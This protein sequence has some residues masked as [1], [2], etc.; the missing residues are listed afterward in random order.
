MPGAIPE[1]WIKEYVDQLLAC[2]EKFP[3]GAMRDSA[4]LR[5][6]NVMDMVKAYREYGQ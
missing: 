5:A 1:R 4:L 6:D 2:A 3:E